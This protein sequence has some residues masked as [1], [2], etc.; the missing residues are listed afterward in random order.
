MRPVRAG[1]FVEATGVG[2]ASRFSGVAVQDQVKHG[3][4]GSYNDAPD[5]TRKEFRR[6]A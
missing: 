4:E 3:C 5:R 2:A 6:P 1:V